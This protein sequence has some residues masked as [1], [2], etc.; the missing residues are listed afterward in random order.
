[1]LA[2]LVQCGEVAGGMVKKLGLPKKILVLT[3]IPVFLS[4]PQT[5]KVILASGYR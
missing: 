1:M 3:L 4:L 2:H 5:E